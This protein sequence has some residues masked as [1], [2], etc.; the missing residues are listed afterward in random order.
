MAADSSPP[1]PRS[2][3]A[4]ASYEIHPARRAPAALRR[5]AAS[6]H[7]ADPA[8]ERPPERRRGR[9]RGGR[10]AGSRPTSR[11][12]RSRSRPRACCSRTSP[13]CRPSSTSRRCGTR[14]PTSAATREDQPADPGR[15]RDRPLGAGRRVRDADRLPPQR[16]ARVRAQ[17]RALRVPALGPDGASTTSRSSRRAPASSTRSTSSTSRAWSRR[18]TAL[19]FPDTLV[20]TDSHTTM[21]NGLGVLGW[22]VG[23]IEAEAAMLGEALSML[24]PQVVG[25][26]LTGALPEGATATDLV[27]TVTRD[28]APDRRRRQVRRVLRPRARRA[29]AR[30]PRDDRE[31]VARV[32]RDLRLLPGRRRRRS[33]TCA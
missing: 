16:R 10:G 17:P 29:P 14:W 3:S 12:A 23:G 11:A 4:T 22:G 32:R 26:Q 5:R 2:P 9:R 8:R 1:A 19:A 27:L 25:F 6:L 15:A 21:V 33:S 28:P 18:A 7:A 31:H 20:G 30:R 13:A 24:V